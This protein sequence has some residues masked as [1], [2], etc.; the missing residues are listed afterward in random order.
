MGWSLLRLG[1]TEEALTHARASVR[2]AGDMGT[3]RLR[4]MALNLLCHALPTDSTASA[5]AGR[6][7]A[8]IG[9]RLEDEELIGRYDGGA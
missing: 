8:Q 7:A 4:A 5:E 9:K 1:R 3:L 6:R 2:E